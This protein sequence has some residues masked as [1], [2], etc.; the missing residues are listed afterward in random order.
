MKAI[1]R[2]SFLTRSKSTLF[3]FPHGGQM[4]LAEI[5]ESCRSLSVVEKREQS[6]NAAELVFLNEQVQE[7][8]RILTGVLGPPQKPAG[9]KPSGEDKRVSQDFGGVDAHQTL[10]LKEFGTARI[11]AMF[12]P[13]K[14][15]VNTT[16]KMYLV[17][18]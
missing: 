5:L 8:Q 17:P 13:W 11:I 6:E 2:A 14:N 15:K 7:W 12:W 9:K 3:D 18:R 10:F 4:T 1:V 16:L